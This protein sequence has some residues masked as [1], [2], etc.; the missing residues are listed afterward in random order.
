[1]VV[2]VTGA[3]V[4]VVMALVVLVVLVLVVLVRVVLLVV[5]L[6]VVVVR[7]RVVVE[8]RVV[9]T[10]VKELGIE[11]W[12]VLVTGAIELVEITTGVVGMTTTGTDDV[13]RDVVGIGAAGELRLG[14]NIGMAADVDA[15][16][17]DADVEGRGD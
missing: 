13:L 3:I 14:V 1:M 9:R 17:T 7:A 8:A 6:L 11:T 15:G 12:I 16:G 4:A 5:V 2:V 10:V